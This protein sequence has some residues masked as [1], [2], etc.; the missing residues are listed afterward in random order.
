MAQKATTS[1]NTT[2][3]QPG[4]A[5]G[6][7]KPATKKSTPRTQPKP[8]KR[9]APRLPLLTLD[10]MLDGVGV[11]L[12]L[13]GLLTGLAML[14]SDQPSMVQPWLT[15]LAALFGT[16]TFAAPIAFIALGVWL[17]ARR[18]EN[19]PAPPWYRLL[20]G[21]LVA[22]SLFGALGLVQLVREPGV[23]GGY[24]G[25]VG[26]AIAQA[27]TLAIGQAGAA[28][29]LLFVGFQGLL[30]LLKLSM[31]DVGRG[32]TRLR[33]R[34]V[35][36]AAAP[37]DTRTSK[38]AIQMPLPSF[39]DV[40]EQTR[41]FWHQIRH[42]LAA[43]RGGRSAPEPQPAPSF[44]GEPITSPTP[45]PPTLPAGPWELPAWAQIL[46]A[47][48]DTTATDEDIRHKT[49]IIEETLAHFGVPAHV[50]EINRGPT[51]TQ[52]GVEPGFVRRR[53]RG[54]EREL[55]VKVSA[56]TNL[57][58]DLALALAAQR[59]RIEAPVPGRSYVG[60]EV[61][62]DRAH[63]V[64]LRDTMESEE[65][66][67]LASP[68]R[69]ALGRD[70]MGNAVVADL[71]QM[72]HLLIAGSTG[73]GK[74][75][76]INT[77][78]CNLLCHNS[79][80][81]LKLLMVD[82]KMV[83]LIGYNGIPHLI[84]PVV[85]D[86]ERVVGM[87]RWAVNEMERRYKLF[88]EQRVRNLQGYNARALKMGERPL[89][90]LVLIIDELADLMMAAA[91]QVEGMICRLAQMAR[92]TGMHLI[93]ATQRPSVDVVTGLI[94]A[95][96]PA[97]IAFAV[98]SQIDSRVILDRPGA[99]ALLGRGD[100]LYMASDSGALKR[101]QGCFVSDRELEQINRHWLTQAAHQRQTGH[102]SAHPHG[103]APVPPVQ[104]VLW[105]ELL[106]G[107]SKEGGEEDDLLPKA[108]E[109]VAKAGSASISMLQR[110]LRVGYARAA[111][112]VDLLEAEGTIG[113]SEGP[114]KNR[115]V[116]KETPEPGSDEDPGYDPS[117]V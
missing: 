95:N 116:Y 112:L 46:E 42:T 15:L 100:M 110:R 40:V 66:Q 71:A 43:R 20:G 23:M 39:P 109:L 2:R 111:R 57:H 37:P 27:L 62:N 107:A 72:P 25:L 50:V 56:I 53:V 24:G 114:G 4:N 64:M 94:K 45:A 117:W 18:F 69:V 90:Y 22:L 10:Q 65:F 17:I 87:L 96:F 16:L 88:S 29:T 106:G 60:I 93:L 32:M 83:E 82:P 34:R 13:L 86:L 12:T 31:A 7:R 54:E 19:A 68:L 49:R 76:C 44:N 115:E 84:V 30:F 14:P 33:A 8:P 77:I 85:T 28:G 51:V 92:A 38:R 35:A 99:E 67:G 48:P 91:D 79:P 3:K 9:Q 47:K 36:R 1:K 97:R 104:S 78:I 75:V 61:P 74:S 80:D 113:S 101:A 63:A 58:N 73:S 70:V 6:T 21:L 11:L 89:P 55:K 102:T 59:I 26:L 98:T 105:D 81:Q 5:P 41:E 52:Y 103:A 108:R